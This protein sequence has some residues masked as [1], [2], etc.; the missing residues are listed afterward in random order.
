MLLLPDTITMHKSGRR[1]L[2][3]TPAMAKYFRKEHLVKVYPESFGTWTKIDWEFAR[4]LWSNTILGF[5]CFRGKPKLKEVKEVV[6][7]PLMFAIFFWLTDHQDM[8][9]YRLNGIF[10]GLLKGKNRKPLFPKNLTPQWIDLR[11]FKINR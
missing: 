2:G 3:G 4:D 6:W 5:D 7:Y 9:N 10:Y 1:R 11:K 8:H